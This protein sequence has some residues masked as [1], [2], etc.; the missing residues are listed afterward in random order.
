VATADENKMAGLTRRLEDARGA[1]AEEIAT[2][3]LVEAEADR[4]RAGQ[5]AAEDRLA[6]ILVGCEAEQTT[7]RVLLEAERSEAAVQ[8]A[9]RT[10]RFEPQACLPN[11]RAIARLLERAETAASSVRHHRVPAA[12][13]AVRM[14]AGRP[15]QAGRHGAMCPGVGFGG[16]LLAMG[17]S[18]HATTPGRE[19]SQLAALQRHCPQR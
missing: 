2:P 12:N 19:A 9:A 17:E 11:P 3:R 15:E 7:A 10:L 1:L 13:H 5:V 8:D 18:W 6:E 4:A 14:V 16:H